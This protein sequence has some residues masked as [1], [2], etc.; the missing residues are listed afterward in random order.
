MNKLGIRPSDIHI[1]V[2]Y[3][4]ALGLEQHFQE[5]MSRLGHKASFYA[6][7]DNRIVPKYASSIRP[8]IIQQD[9]QQF[10]KLEQE[11]IFYHDSDILFRELPDFSEMLWND[12]WYV[13]DTRVYLDSRYVKS[14]GGEPLLLEMCNIVGIHP[15]KVVAQDPNCG[16]AQYL[17]KNTTVE[18]WQKL[19]KDSEHLYTYMNEFNARSVDYAE[20]NQKN[21]TIQAWCADMWG[22]L[23]NAL[24]YEKTVEIHAEMD[25]CWADTS[26][27]N[28]KKKKIL[29]YTGSVAK[30]NSKLFRKT[31]YSEYYPF[32]DLGLN[33]IDPTSCSSALVEIIKKY[34][35][36]LEPSRIDLS[37]TLL[38]VLVNH[39][40]EG[41]IDVLTTQL[42]YLEKFFT[43]NIYIIETG[44][45]QLHNKITGLNT[46]G[47]NFFPIE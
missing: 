24:Y 7:P 5:L 11:T 15:E 2:G 27:E 23:W 3:K 32:Y 29:H 8:H 20:K 46:Y 6:Y 18:F 42:R 33:K 10:P 4:P 25:F 38:F 47:Y 22:L 31:N 44:P 34:V 21:K 13:S 19:E 16:G 35:M 28:W 37:D 17:L 9:F 41:S 30:D 36:E 43:I 1:L 40:G 45:V 39:E 12:K 14:F 26:I